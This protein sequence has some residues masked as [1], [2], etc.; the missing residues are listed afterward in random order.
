MT[1]RTDASY[2]KIWRLALP[3]M[4]ANISVPLLGGVDT[5]VVGHLPDPAL[6]GGVALGSVIFSFLYW[7]F[8]FL[9]MGTTG[10]TAQALGAANN[11]EVRAAL[12]RP[13]LLGLLLSLAL[14][15]LQVPI[16]RL[17]LWSIEGSPAVEAATATYYHIRIWSAPAALVNFTV[18]GWLLG[19]QRTGTTLW[20]Q[21]LLNGTNIILDLLFV[22]G[23]DWGIAG[24]ASAT[25]ISE[26]IAALVGLYVILRAIRQRGGSWDRQRILRRDRLLALLRV[27]FDI[28][29]RTVSL[30]F[31]FA[32]FTAL[33]ARMGDSLLAANAVL[34][35]INTF[36]AYGLDGFANA[37][38]I[39]A[40]N[41]AGARD[42]QGFRLAVRNSTL[43]ALG[44]S[45][46]FSLFLLVLGPQV[47]GLYSNI[48]AVQEAALTYLPW[49]IV[50]P[51]FSVWCFQLDGIFVGA[52]RT[53][54]MRNAMVVSLPIYLIACWLLVPAYGNHGLWLALMIFMVGRALTLGAFYP[55][56]ERSLEAPKTSE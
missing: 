52:T 39:L 27:N 48:A 5:A 40:G 4:L 38:E 20:L 26:V 3:I 47:V 2:G 32:Y 42:R 46:A 1:E 23:F 14:V 33:G 49:V 9:R 29:I 44:S 43:C 24:V 13:L 11:D 7:G 25:V 30:L 51:L 19:M 41:A 55:A 45:A 37:V 12:V 10:F 54:A 16:A 56:L 53:A 22:L 15:A 31:A 28:F 8:G 6:I 50:S 34:L 35:N 17:A 36:I 18:I 21:L